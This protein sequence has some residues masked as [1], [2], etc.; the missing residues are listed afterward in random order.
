MLDPYAWPDAECLHNRLGIKDPDK[1]LQA[2][3]FLVA[4]RD[5]ELARETLP[6]EYNLEHLRS[7]H[8]ALFRDVYDWAGQTRTVDISKPGAR[9]AHWR[10][11]DDETSRVLH[12]LYDD[13]FRRGLRREVF[14]ERLAHYYGELNAMYP[15]R[16]GN[17]RTS[18]AFLRQLA[19][20]AGFRLDWSEL[21]MEKNL[22][23][24]QHNLST[25]STTLLVEVLDPVVAR[26]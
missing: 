11:V 12:G 22:H 15:F 14:I 16:E 17:G 19:A 2:E 6:G 26:L 25:A 4:I 5:A 13:G 21:S 18:R 7:F 20:A 9:F 1:L 23:A 24:C 10:H 3:T 8:H